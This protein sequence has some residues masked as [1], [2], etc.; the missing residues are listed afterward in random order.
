MRPDGGSEWERGVNFRE[1]PSGEESGFYFLSFHQFIFHSLSPLCLAISVKTQ[2]DK[3][4][5]ARQR[6][7]ERDDRVEA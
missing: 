6:K 5:V 3:G 7:R 1:V 4:L 2:Q